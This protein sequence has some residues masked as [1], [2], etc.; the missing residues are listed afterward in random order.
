MSSRPQSHP[1]T[2]GDTTGNSNGLL[3]VCLFLPSLTFFDPVY[4]DTYDGK[5]ILAPSASCLN[6][7][8][9]YN[10]VR[11]IYEGLGYFILLT[12]KFKGLCLT[13]TT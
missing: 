11:L 13:G 6:D 10:S 1:C 3:L 12:G 8:Y 4:E 2:C 7:K 9:M 5:Q